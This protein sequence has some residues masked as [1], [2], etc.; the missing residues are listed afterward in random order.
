MR[1][2]VVLLLAGIAVLCQSGNV[3]RSYPLL[4]T[5]KLKKLLNSEW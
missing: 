5:F 1:A 4:Y 3:Y 2:F